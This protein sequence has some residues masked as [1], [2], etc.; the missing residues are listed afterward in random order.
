VFTGGGKLAARF[1]VSLSY[2]YAAVGFFFITYA[3]TLFIIASFNWSNKASVRC[4]TAFAL[5]VP[6]AGY[7]L[8]GKIG[9]D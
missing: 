4:I 9:S 7:A 8:V 6:L 2:A 1:S 3:R 5:V